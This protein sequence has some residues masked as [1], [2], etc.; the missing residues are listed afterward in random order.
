MNPY[1]EILQALSDASIRYLAVGD[2]A[3]NLHG[4]RRFTGDID[5]LLALDEENLE[6]MTK[7]MHSM[8]YTERL[9]VEL[10]SLAKREQVQ[11]WMEEKGM[12]AYTFLSARRLRLDIDVLAGAS[13]RF[14]ELADRKSMVDIDGE[15]LVPVIS[16]DDLIAM[17]REAHRPQ[18]VQDIEAL[19][20][21]KGL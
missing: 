4:Y 7:L 15:F 18:D 19:L 2:V 8:G 17:K 20:A 13:L 5:L 21:L 9:P 6:K 1:R 14:E 11:K 16:F 10:K 3:V 12:T